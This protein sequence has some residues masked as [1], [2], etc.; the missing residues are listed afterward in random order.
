MTTQEKK[1]W[2]CGCKN[3]KEQG[4][5]C[6][7]CPCHTQTEEESAYKI[8]TEELPNFPPKREVTPE[9][10]ERMLEIIRNNKR[11]ED[12]DLQAQIGEEN[13]AEIIHNW[14]L[15]A[16]KEIKPESYNVKAQKTYQDL[17]EEQKFL[18]RYMARKILDLL[19]TKEAEIREDLREK[20]EELSWYEIVNDQRYV[21]K[22][23]LLALLDNK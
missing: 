7:D 19:T 12:K 23:E 2:C 9:A 21:S 13:L 22:W 1:E 4:L 15:E 18:D 20:I 3:A 17:T 16:C 5:N 14:Y 8:H 6:P 10:T 11:L